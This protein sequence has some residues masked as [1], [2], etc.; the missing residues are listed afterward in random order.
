M[1]SCSDYNGRAPCGVHG[2]IGKALKEY[3]KREVRNLIGH[4]CRKAD[5]ALS[6]RAEQ[7]NF[8]D[9]QTGMYKMMK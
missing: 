3:E 9:G 1:A 7:H 5:I 8:N 2:M 4:R 6:Q